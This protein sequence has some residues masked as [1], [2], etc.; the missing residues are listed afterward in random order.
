MN[1]NHFVMM[2]SVFS[3]LSVIFGAFGAHSLKDRIPIESLVIFETAVRYQMYHGLALLVLGVVATRIDSLPLKLA[4]GSFCLGIL[5]F[6][7]S[8]F[9]LALTPYRMVGIITPVGGLFLVAGWLSMVI[10][11]SKLT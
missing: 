9:V 4:G 11:M 7:G 3:G 6:S 10:A 1:W 8:L 5:L 2:G